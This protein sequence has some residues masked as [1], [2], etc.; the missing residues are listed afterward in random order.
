MNR[1]TDAVAGGWELSGIATF[2]KGIPLGI[3]GNDYSSYGGNPRPDVIGNPQ[4]PKTI[5]EWFNT[6]AFAYAQYGTFGTAPR[7]FG[8]LRGPGYQDWDTTLEKNWQFRDKMRA[9]FRF[10]TFNTF[11]HPNFYAP[12]AGSTSYSGCD[13]NAT[14]CGGSFG[15]ITA[16]FPA[17]S[18]QWAG[19]FYW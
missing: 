2:R 1:I 5:H 3:F 16:A 8:N 11:N 10:E 4:G 12:G 18:V 7:F 14:A 17:R 13:P 15:Q 6:G 9:Q 19:K